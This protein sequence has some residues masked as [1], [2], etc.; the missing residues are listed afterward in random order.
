MLEEEQMLDDPRRP[1][2][3]RVA[4]LLAQV[5]DLLGQMRQVERQIGLITRDTTQLARLQLRPGVEILV[6]EPGH[7]RRHFPH[8]A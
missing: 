2:S 1:A 3:H 8:I 4:L 5:P 6:V 7:V